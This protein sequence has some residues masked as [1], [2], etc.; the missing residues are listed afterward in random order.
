MSVSLQRQRSVVR[1]LALGLDLHSGRHARYQVHPIRHLI[2]S[3]WMRTGMRCARRTQVKIGL[4]EASPSWFG[5]AFVTLI[6][7]AMLST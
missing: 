3:M 1:P 7:W 5:C 2:L 6:A 4:T